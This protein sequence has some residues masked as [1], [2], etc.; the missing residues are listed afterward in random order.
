MSNWQRN[1]A[2]YKRWRRWVTA[3]WDRFKLRNMYE[4]DKVGRS[5]NK[6]STA[7]REREAKRKGEWPNDLSDLRPV[8]SD[9]R[10]VWLQDARTALLLCL[11]ITQG[12]EKAWGHS[13]RNGWETWHSHSGHYRVCQWAAAVN[14]WQ[15]D[16]HRLV[17]PITWQNFTHSWETDRQTDRTR[18]GDRETPDTEMEMQVRGLRRRGGGG[19][20]AFWRMELDSN[21]LTWPRVQLPTVC[22]WESDL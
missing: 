6:I 3:R 4:G 14:A 18:L 8:F 21:P 9:L 11:I 22:V 15:S 19:G 12:A 7:G 17:N 13:I 1:A 20:G 2:A 5:E 16:I 10:G